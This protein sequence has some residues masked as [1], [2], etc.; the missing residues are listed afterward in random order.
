M[1]GKASL[2]LLVFAAAMLALNARAGVLLHLSM[3]EMTE[4]SSAILYGRCV[5][6]KAVWTAA[7]P[8][9]TEN[10]FQ[11]HEYYKGNLG[12]RVTITELGGQVG[13]V[14]DDFPGVP[15]FQVGEEAVLF[16]WTGPNGRHHVIGQSQGRFRVERDAKTGAMLVRQSSS[17]EPMI[18]PASHSHG[19]RV[20]PLAFSMTSFRGQ[21]AASVERAAQQKRAEGGRQ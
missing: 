16:V 10:V 21:V 17:G 15:R 2:L 8:I 13:N 1:T 3:D 12:S 5:E 7:S 19:G 14:V 11:V 9:V 20:S 4:Q 6:V 18:E